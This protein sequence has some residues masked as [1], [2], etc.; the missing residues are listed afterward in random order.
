VIVLP[1]AGA[2]GD[3][4]RAM[5]E[6][7]FD[8]GDRIAV[9]RVSAPAP[10]NGR[11]NYPL[12]ARLGAAVAVQATVTPTGMRVA[13]HD[14]AKRSVAQTRRFA[15]TDA[16][17]APAWRMAVHTA[18]DDLEFA[19][20]GMR[21]ISADAHRV[22]ARGPDLRRSTATARTR[23]RSRR[24]GRSRS[25]RRGTPLGS[26]SRTPDSAGAAGRRCSSAT[27]PARRRARGG[28]RRAVSTS[29]PPSRPTATPWSTRTASTPAPTS[30]PP[31]RSTTRRAAA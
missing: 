17:L 27:S 25:R 9:V 15:L 12:L 4:L 29:R 2:N 30:S 10:V 24:K 8:Y 20:T 3:S 23:G 31:R 14:V 18:A 26:T 21:G 7:D 13:L 28:R 11:L 22:H 16:A 5:L 19:I 6:R 1:I